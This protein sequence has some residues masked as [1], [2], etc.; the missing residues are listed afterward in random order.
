M[1]YINSSEAFL[2]RL[3]IRIMKVF[4]LKLVLNSKKLYSSVFT[5]YNYL[6]LKRLVTRIKMLLSENIPYSKHANKNKSSIQVLTKEPID[7]FQAGR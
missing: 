6:Y 4:L 5:Y 7:K 3:C 2:L 1:A